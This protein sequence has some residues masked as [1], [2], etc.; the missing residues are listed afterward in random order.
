MKILIVEDDP[1]AASYLTQGLVESGHQVDHVGD[2]DTALRQASEGQYD[3]LILDRMLPG[4]DGT[5][6]V[7][8]LRRTGHDVPILM[9]TALGDVTDRI[10]GLRA[11]ADDYLPKP[12][13]FAELLARIETITRRR[14]PDTNTRILR[15]ADLELDTVSRRASR[16]GVVIR[17]QPREFRLLEYLMRSAGRVLN[18][19]ELLEQVWGYRFDPETNVVDMH[20]SRLRRKIDKDFAPPLL[21]TV[22]GA[23]Y[24]LRDPR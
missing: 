13:S 6:V 14:Q 23:G 11:G 18:R 8:A 17:L 12:F 20:I 1:L 9:L 10:D 24:V 5:E 4:R 7:A 19:V 16:A 21:V 22:R 2:G 15:V 3:A